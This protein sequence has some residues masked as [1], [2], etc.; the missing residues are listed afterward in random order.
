MSPKVEDW[1]RIAYREAWDRQKEIFNALIDDREVDVPSVP[2]RVVLVEHDPVYTLGFHG[3]ADN[4]LAS[5]E[6]LRRLGAE[7]I[8]I[9]RGGDITY[10]GPGQLVVYPMLNIV[11]R[12]LGVKKYIELLENAVIELLHTYGI[13]SSSNGDAIGVWLDWGMPGARKVCAIGVKVSHGI[14]MHGLALNVT[15]DLNAFSEINP[16][17]F[18][19][20]GVT[21]IA[22]EL[23]TVSESLF[24]EVKSRFAE[25]LLR[26]LQ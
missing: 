19:D 25:I 9:E 6:R 12:G 10:H 26:K 11:R 20:K 15:T 23:G 16:C 8:R 13:E 7:C 5:E 1:G 22:R 3:N 17:G 4:M 18:T 14:T 2:E 24:D 21:S